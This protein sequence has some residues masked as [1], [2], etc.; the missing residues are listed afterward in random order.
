M[1]NELSATGFEYAVRST[2]FA[3]IRIK[4]PPRLPPQP[5]RRDVPLAQRSRTV[6]RIAEPWLEDV[7]DRDTGVEADQIGK[8]QRTHRVI[9]PEFH[10]RVDRFRSAN[11]LHDAVDGLVDHRHQDAIRYETG[12]VVDLDRRLA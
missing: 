8:R 6:L 4:P 7:H 10:H 12:K 11:T 5:P 3:L 2:P 1:R 9:H